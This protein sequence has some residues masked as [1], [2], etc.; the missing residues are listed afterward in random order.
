MNSKSQKLI[1]NIN[2]DNYLNWRLCLEDKLKKINSIN[3]VIDCK[4][5][6]LSCTEISDLISIANQYN[7]KIVSFS[8]V[9]TCGT[10]IRNIS[11][12]IKKSYS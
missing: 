4:N 8:G 3:I 2:D 12:F 9:W 6:A 11:G 5:L 7:C 1:I 10:C